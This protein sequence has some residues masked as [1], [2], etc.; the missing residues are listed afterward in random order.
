MPVASGPSSGAAGEDDGATAPAAGAA[1]FDLGLVPVTIDWRQGGGSGVSAPLQSLT[2]GQP[3]S[4]Q[5]VA[6]AVSLDADDIVLS[7]H[8][9]QVVSVGLPLLLANS[10]WDRA[11]RARPT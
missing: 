8:L 7:A 2:L 1:V 9:P 5:S 3:V 11:A 4:A 10:D 6:S